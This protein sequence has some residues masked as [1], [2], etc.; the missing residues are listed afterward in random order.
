LSRIF[1]AKPT[2]IALLAMVVLALAA[3]HEHASAFTS[4]TNLNVGV[5]VEVR[6]SVVTGDLAF[7]SSYVSGQVADLDTVST[8]IVNCDPGRKVAIK[9][10]QGLHP[11]P[12]S[13]DNNPRRR[14]Q[15]GPYYLDYNIYEDAT[16]TTVWDNRSN[17]IKTTRVFPYTATVYGRIPG[18]QAA[19]PGTYSDT[20]ITTVHY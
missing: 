12:G 8:V 18:G 17:A 2:I 11:A 9:M 15:N 19:S 5:A 14:M 4:N 3:A 13:S 7:G 16:Y 6:C 10:G 1:V 20:V